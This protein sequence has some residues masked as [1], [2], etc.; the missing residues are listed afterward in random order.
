MPAP[1]NIT[2]H[3]LPYR[4]LAR[5]WRVPAFLMMPAGV[6]LYWAVPQLTPDRPHIAPLA[7]TV[8][9]VGLLIFLYTLLATQARVTCEQNHLTIRTP[10]YPVVISYQRIDLIRPVEFGSLF[11]PDKAKAA[12]LRLYYELWG[13]TVP[14]LTLKGYPLPRWWLRFWFHPYLFHPQEIGL[15]LPMDDWM[16]FARRLETLRTAQRRNR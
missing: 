4:S 14:T 2:F 13:K 5:R 6:A 1:D 9:F 3:L 12:H 15:V 16:S 7:L 11:P 8:S 10:L